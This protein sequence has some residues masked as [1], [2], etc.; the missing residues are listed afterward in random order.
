MRERQGSQAY[1]DDLRIEPSRLPPADSWE[2]VST[3]GAPISTSLDTFSSVFGE[4]SWFFGTSRNQKK[5]EK[6]LG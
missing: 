1:L 2:G 5:E 3:L 6:G 4:L